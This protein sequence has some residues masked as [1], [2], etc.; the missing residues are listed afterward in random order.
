MLRRTS[1]SSYRVCFTCVVVR[2]ASVMVKGPFGL[3][4]ALP[5]RC[6]EMVSVDETCPITMFS[7][8]PRRRSCVSVAHLLKPGP[9]PLRA[10][11]LIR[12]CLAH[13][14]PSGGCIQGERACQCARRWS[15][16][17]RSLCPL[18]PQVY[19][20]TSRCAVFEALDPWLAARHEA[21]RQ[22]FGP[23]KSAQRSGNVELLHL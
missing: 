18:T 17:E 3:T 23:A 14:L 20:H 16:Q 21:V 10:E 4:A 13:R 7:G 19:E 6:L 5:N 1:G 8:P 2:W 11:Q 9:L 15:Y 22:H 12:W